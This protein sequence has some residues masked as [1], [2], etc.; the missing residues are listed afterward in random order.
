MAKHLKQSGF[1]LVELLVGLTVGALVITAI[2]SAAV[3]GLKHFQTLKKTQ[4]LHSTSV[5]LINTATYWIKNA[6][7]LNLVSLSDLQIK[8]PG[9][10]DFT[11]EIRQNGDAIEI[12][13][14]TG[15]G[16]EHTTA[17][18]ENVKIN[19]LSF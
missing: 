4:L 5:F 19:Y 15:S 16:F 13:T 6:E 1:T 18:P 9:D 17:N 3:S 2:S 7:D 12:G 11:K 8:L 10:T 14:N